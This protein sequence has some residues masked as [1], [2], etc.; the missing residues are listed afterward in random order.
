MVRA[1]AAAAF[2]IGLS[3]PAFCEETFFADDGGSLRENLELLQTTRPL[4]PEIPQSKIRRPDNE[5]K[6]LLLGLIRFYQIFLSS[7]DGDHCGFTPTCSHFGQEALKQYG[8]VEGILMTSDRLQRC[9]GWSN[10][11]YPIDPVT[12]RAIDPVAANASWR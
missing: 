7:Q 6:L 3:M 11:Y 9:N 5:A 1:L 10:S 12:D 4:A 2:L 8:V